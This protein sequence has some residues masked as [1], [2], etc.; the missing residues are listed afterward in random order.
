[1]LCTYRYRQRLNESH[2][3]PL[4]SH[5]SGSQIECYH[6]IKGNSI[7]T[8]RLDFSKLVEPTD[9]RDNTHVTDNCPVCFKYNCY[10]PKCHDD[11]DIVKKYVDIKQRFCRNV[12]DIGEC[13][14][15]C[16]NNAFDMQKEAAMPL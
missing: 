5:Q 4:Y 3:C 8:C 15:I 1:M 7:C 13:D 12:S 14:C 6:L 9:V 11:S 2:Q 16:K 10:F